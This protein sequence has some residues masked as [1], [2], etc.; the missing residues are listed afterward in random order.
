MEINEI[1]KKI[2]QVAIDHGFWENENNWIDRAEGDNKNAMHSLVVAQK[3]ALVHSEVSEVL[4]ADRHGKRADRELYDRA[5]HIVLN[6]LIADIAA[7]E[8]AFKKHI[9]DTVEDEIADAI[10]RLFDLGTWLGM[11]IEWHI[12][13]KVDYNQNRPYLHGKKY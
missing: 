2:H 1:S 3:L 12:Q 11:D 6:D 9:K 13:K 4:E 10:I 7:D 5:T 8:V